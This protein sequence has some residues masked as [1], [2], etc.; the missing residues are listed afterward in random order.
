MPKAIIKAFAGQQEMP[1]TFTFQHYGNCLKKA[2]KLGF[3]FQ[4]LAEH[5]AKPAKGKLLLLRH[6]VD[7]SP[8]NALRFA[9]VENAAGVKS[10]FFVRMHSKHY[11]ALKPHTLKMLEK[12]RD[13]GHEIG[14]HQEV[15]DYAKE[16]GGDPEKIM[17]EDKKKLE[18]A[19]GI[20]I[21]GVSSHG[22]FTGIDN[23]GF[24]K[25]RNPKDYGFD[26]DAF[27]SDCFFSSDSLGKWKHGEC[28]CMLLAK[29]DRLCLL[30]HP[31]YWFDEKN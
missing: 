23:S 13:L 2:R 27:V 31:L 22:D 5:N 20:E 1:C 24:W 12:I 17:R 3:S 9:E 11:D 6:D 15:L 28:L 30:T 8:P 18:K 21:T 10:T 26:Y 14:L 19:L 29:H 25:T 7:F 4:T 16:S